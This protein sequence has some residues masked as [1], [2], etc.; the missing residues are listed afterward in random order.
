MTDRS[1]KELRLPLPLRGVADCLRQWL[2]WLALVVLVLGLLIACWSFPA[3]H[4][5]VETARKMTSANQ[6]RS[7]GKAIQQYWMRYGRLPP[8]ASR[9]A[10]GQPLLSWRVH[11]L[12][13]L[14]EAGLYKQF[15]MDESWDSKNNRPLIGQMPKIYAEPGN[16][17]KPANLAVYDG[18][19]PYLAVV[20]PATL[21]MRSD[22]NGQVTEREMGTAESLLIEADEHHA[23]IW[24]KPD[25][26]A[27]SEVESL[28]WRS[29]GKVLVLLANE[30]IMS[31][32]PKTAGTHP[33]GEIWEVR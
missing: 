18:R 27:T 20:G 25:D 23:A 9:N 11:L 6:M 10:N 22:K 32:N 14:N 17:N 19:T 7:I 26:I 15:H 33:Q 2:G 1:Q 21:F 3:T 12:P 5:A 24:T 28:S 13:F 30:Q 29:D 31:A 8:Q 4:E 16:W